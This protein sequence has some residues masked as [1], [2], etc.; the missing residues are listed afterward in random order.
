MLENNHAPE[1]QSS[2]LMKYVVQVCVALLIGTTIFLSYRLN[3]ASKKLAQVEQLSNTDH[4]QLKKF[5]DI[6]GQALDAQET[7]NDPSP[8]D[9]KVS[10][11]VF[12]KISQLIKQV[13][14]LSM[15]PVNPEKSSSG[16]IKSSE[17]IKMPPVNAEM[18]WW[19]KVGNFIFEPVKSYFTNLVKIQVLDNPVDKLA[20]TVNSQ[21]LI[22]EELMLRL[23]SARGLVLHGLLHET[24]SEIDEV[25]KIVEVN[26]SAQDKN[27][28]LFLE[29]VKLVLN[30]LDDLIK[31]RSSNNSVG[32]K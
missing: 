9:V 6:L 30:D 16:A 2:Q 7:S 21:K 28:Q 27:T 19:S 11:E 14:H 25:K 12:Q 20:M 3:L 10:V 13:D 5:S 18:R 32:G 26:F 22:K 4:Q 23:F 17:L 1:N 29:D 24:V 31:K 15:G 8:V